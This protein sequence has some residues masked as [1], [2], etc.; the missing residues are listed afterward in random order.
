MSNQ[1]NPTP[2]AEEASVT[3]RDD[4]VPIAAVHLPKGPNRQQRR[5]LYTL[6]GTFDSD[7]GRAQVLANKRDGSLLFV[8]P[9]DSIYTINRDIAFNQ[10]FSYWELKKDLASDP[11]NQND[12]GHSLTDTGHEKE[13]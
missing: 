7:H 11:A 6:L 10:I 2:P 9:D 13:D 4:I 8:M 12:A 1:E 3:K 5:T